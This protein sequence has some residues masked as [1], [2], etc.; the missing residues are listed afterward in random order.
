MGSRRTFGMYGYRHNDVNNLID[1]IP[2]IQWKYFS[3]Y[4][5]RNSINGKN[6][7]D[8]IRMTCEISGWEGDALGTY[9]EGQLH[10]IVLVPQGTCNNDSDA[11]VIC[12]M[13]KNKRKAFRH[14]TFSQFSLVD[15]EAIFSDMEDEID[16]LYGVCDKSTDTIDKFNDLVGELN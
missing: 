13:H 15:E 10:L 7:F 1:I 16:R 12:F 6:I 2:G 9:G 14:F 4:D 3:F 5:L 11:Y 8:F